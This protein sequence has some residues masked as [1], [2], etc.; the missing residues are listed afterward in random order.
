MTHNQKGKGGGKY[1]E[2]AEPVGEPR[3]VETTHQ[4]A[5]AL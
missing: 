3:L 5:R 4:Y 1:Q 2:R